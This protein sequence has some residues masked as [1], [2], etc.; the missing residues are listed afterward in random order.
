MVWFVHNQN[1]EVL[2]MWKIKYTCKL[3]NKITDIHCKVKNKITDIHVQS[4]K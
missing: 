1:A 4:K 3:K 2:I